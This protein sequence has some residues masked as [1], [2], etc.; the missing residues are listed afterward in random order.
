MQLLQKDPSR[1][2]KSAHDVLARLCQIE[3][4]APAPNVAAR[5]RPPLAVACAALLLTA[6][7]IAAAIFYWQTPDGRVVRIE[8]NDP[9]IKLAFGDGELKVV[10]AYKEPITLRPGKVNLQITR[11]VAD[12]EDF[13][14]ET[15][16]LI[17][18]KG[19][20][21]VLK[22]EVLEGEVQLVQDGKG[23]IDSKPLPA[24][25]GQI[26]ASDPDRAAAEWVLSIGGKVQVN[27]HN[28]TDS[29]AGLPKERF[30]VT[31]VNLATNASVTDAGLAHCRGLKRLTLLNLDSA[32]VTDAGLKHLRGLDRLA[33]LRLYGTR[34]TDAGLIHLQGLEE[35]EELGLGGGTQV[36]D[37]G[38]AQLKS[39][40]G[41]TR[42]YLDGTQVTNSSLPLFKDFREL[43]EL[44]LAGTAVTDRG[45]AHLKEIKRLNSLSLHHTAATDVAMEHLKHIPAMTI[46]NV[47]GTRVTDQGL[48][49][50]QGLKKLTLLYVRNTQ[51]SA[52]AL[53]RFHAAVPGCRIFHD[54]G[55]IEA[56]E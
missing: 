17:V 40:R 56:N 45:L 46:L 51:V 6:A 24:A 37:A 5:K 8:S 31:Q 43:T 55:V 34:V 35:L 26:A 44:D 12:G 21:I 30:A 1:R 11:K 41:L 9:S 4:T 38:L 19:D 29:D 54:G 10:G 22:I 27:E 2:P 25:P 14:F 39:L 3:R 36:T 47:D 50:L 20:K 16:K 23:V 32:N 18:S 48:E 15:D 49:H 52:H 7:A 13:R 33:V 53:E 42:L 28:W